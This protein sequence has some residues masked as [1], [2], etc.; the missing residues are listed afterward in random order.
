MT[1]R[2]TLM[3]GLDGYEASV[4]DAMMAAGQLPALQHLRERS[5]C[6]LLDHGSAKRPGLA[7]EHISSGLAPAPVRR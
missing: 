3:I 6:F 5:A 7:W 2:K 4:G 1:P